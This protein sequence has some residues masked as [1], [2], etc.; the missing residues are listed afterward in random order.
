MRDK[1]L[2]GLG[3]KV[4][5]LGLEELNLLARAATSHLEEP[6][7]YGIEVDLVLICH[8]MVFSSLT[9]AQWMNYETG[10][11]TRKWAA[12]ARGDGED[13]DDLREMEKSIAGR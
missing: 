12:A 4:P 9:M 11:T 3:A 6:V 8:R 5:D 10:R 1:N 13:A 2:A 7:D